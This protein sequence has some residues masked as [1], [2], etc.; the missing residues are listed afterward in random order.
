MRRSRCTPW[1]A[2]SLLV[3]AL[4]AAT[5]TPAS[6]SGATVAWDTLIDRDVG[7][8]ATDAVSAGGFT[9]ILLEAAQDCR[10]ARVDVS[11]A[12]EWIRDIGHARRNL[13]CQ[14]IASLDDALFVAM[15]T[16]SRFDGV[17]GSR[18]SDTYL[19]KIGL[20]GTVLWT[21]SWGS[22]ESDV[23]WEVAAAESGI[24]LAGTRVDTA[25]REETPFLRRYDLEGDVAWTHYVRTGGVFLA[26]AADATGAYVNWHDFETG[27]AWIR[28]YDADGKVGWTSRTL[29]G[30]TEPIDIVRTDEGLFATG[31]TTASLG[32]RTFGGYDVWVAS[33]DPLT[34]RFSWI[35]KFGS[36][37]ND[38]GNGIGVGPA[39]ITVTGSTGGQLTRFASHGGYDAFV[40]GYAIGGKRRWMR[41][42]GTFKFDEGRAVIADATGIVVIGET[43]GNL[44]GG[45]VD[46]NAA[47]LRRWEPA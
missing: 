5:A 23:A 9:F 16:S 27:D 47:F 19:R 10:I 21:R 35:R 25:N 37:A 34:G 3:A 12:V 1:L 18:G 38:F 4:T 41:Q 15:V 7:G 33:L 31:D 17:R 8:E 46:R 42:F 2:T 39:G 32:R 36:A 14:G 43:E 20:D 24:Y 28:H 6:A 11:G 29:A 44:G 13:S 22:A 40:R 45:H 26:V 30:D